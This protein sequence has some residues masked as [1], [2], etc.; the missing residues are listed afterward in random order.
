MRAMRMGKAAAIT[1]ILLL[2]LVTI[3]LIY[4]VIFKPARVER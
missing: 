2:I 4:Q 3:M 1:T